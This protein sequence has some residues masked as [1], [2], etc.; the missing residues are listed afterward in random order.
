MGVN[1][2]IGIL[3]YIEYLLSPSISE[4]VVFRGSIK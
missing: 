1:K 4:I 3:K 2:D